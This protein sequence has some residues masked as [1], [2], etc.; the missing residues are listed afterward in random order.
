MS[1]HL[2]VRDYHLELMCQEQLFQG[3]NLSSSWPFEGVLKE[4]ATSV[5]EIVLCEFLKLALGLLK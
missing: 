5:L 4:F 2:F 3:T 1:E